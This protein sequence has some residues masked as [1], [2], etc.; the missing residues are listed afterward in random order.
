[1][2]Y[3]V[4]MTLVPRGLH[5]LHMVPRGRAYEADMG[6]YSHMSFMYEYCHIGFICSHVGEQSKRC[7]LSTSALLNERQSDRF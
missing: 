2:T 7:N 4:H 3:E 5:V 6:I 1:M